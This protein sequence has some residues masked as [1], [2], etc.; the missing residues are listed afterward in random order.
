MLSEL[1]IQI[2][3]EVRLLRRIMEWEGNYS[4]IE[5]RD[6]V[7]NKLTHHIS[8][9]TSSILMREDK[10]RQSIFLANG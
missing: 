7:I 3:Q 5:E 6:W 8:D 10:E 1:P 4:S 9:I 2:Q